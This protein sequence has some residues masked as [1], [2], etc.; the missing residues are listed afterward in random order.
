MI[1]LDFS[2]TALAALLSQLGPHTNIKIEENMVRCMVLNN[3]RFYKQKFGAQ[4]GEM[5]IAC[6]SNNYWRKKIF[7][8]YKANRKKLQEES[9]LNWHEIFEFLDQIKSELKQYFPYKILDIE[10]CE[11][12]DIIGT[13]IIRKLGEYKYEDCEIKSYNLILSGDKDFIQLQVFNNVK[14]YDPVK[15]KW[16]SHTDPPAYLVEHILKGD[17]NDGIPNVIS[18]D[19]CIV[20]EVRQKH[21]TKKKIELIKNVYDFPTW[22]NYKRNESLISLW[23]VP[24]S[25]QERILQQYYDQ[26]LKNRSRLMG[27]FMDHRLKNLVEHICDF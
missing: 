15:K 26:E 5:V 8:H 10:T 16:I 27:Y 21:L 25:L 19:D 6:D 3:I 7:P 14:Q 17:R 24:M 23:Q 20:K 13:L 11:A 22:V 2:Q 1:L 18:P 9:E 4:Y 12:D